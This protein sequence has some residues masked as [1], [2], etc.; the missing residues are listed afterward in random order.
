MNVC[1]KL[2]ES[3]NNK[4]VRNSG[5]IIGQQIFQ[6]LLQLIVGV[7]TARYLGPANYGA[8]NYTAS[9]VT[10]FVSITTLGMEGVVIKKLIDHPDDEGLYLGSAMGLRFLASMLSIVSVSLLVFVLN[11]SEP[12]KLTL[13]F[14]QSFQLSFKAIGI[15]DS[16]FQRHLKSKY[17]SIGKMLACVVVSAYKVFLLV[18]AKSIVWFALSSSLTECV[19]ALVECY[20]YKRQRGQRLRF[21]LSV[22]S[23]IL[24]ESYHFIISGLMV[25]IYSQM[26]R[27]MIG[28]MMTDVDVGLYTTATAVC[29]LWIFVPMALISSF[30]PAVMELKRNGNDERYLL[31]LK[32]LYSAVIW[33]CVIVS[34]G[35]TLLA[36]PIIYILYGTQ[37]LGAVGTLRIAI[38]SETFAMIGSVRGVW[39]LC[40]K[41]NKYVKYYLMMGAAV[42]LVLN[43]LLIPRAGINGAAFATLVT[44]AV[45]SLLAPALFK[46]TRAHVP[47]VLDAALLG[48][49]WRKNKS[50]SKEE[51]HEP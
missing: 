9:F 43:A 17:V 26:D 5:W 37:Y 11:P 46:E 42:N 25:A 47:I 15:L 50:A 22:G 18:T 10:F 49:Y 32:Q 19:I 20:F 3:L 16:W 40:E 41:K 28:E 6:M 29:G 12:I 14:L 48:W 24:K 36:K 44:Q 51:D 8:L 27:I 4:S 33:L 39:I 7:L 31:R 38:W 23:G 35:I 21:R 13:V 1:H 30:Q 34:G 2:K 45:T